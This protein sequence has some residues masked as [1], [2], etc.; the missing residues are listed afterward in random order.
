MM[1]RVRDPNR[2]KAFEIY[3]KHRGNIQNREISQKLNVPEKTISGW[4]CKD[5]WNQKL[6]GVLRIKKECRKRCHR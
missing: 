2:G 4:K 3:K 6:N 5:K 1:L